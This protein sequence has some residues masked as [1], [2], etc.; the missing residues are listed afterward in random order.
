MQAEGIRMLNER[1]SQ[2]RIGA[3]QNVVIDFGGVIRSAVLNNCSESG[4]YIESGI[5]F[6]SGIAFNVIIP[7]EGPPIE[8]PVSVIWSASAGIYEG[9]G[10]RVQEV[11]ANYLQYLIRL[12]LGS[13]SAWPNL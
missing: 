10:V 8:V 3:D 12:E 7:I 9:M 4:M 2:R 13:L 1:R 6:S 11:S 5:S